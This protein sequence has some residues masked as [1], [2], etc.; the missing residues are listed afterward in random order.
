MAPPSKRRGALASQNRGQKSGNRGQT[1]KPKRRQGGKGK[2]FQKGQETPGE[3]FPPGVSGNP[4]GRPRALKEV[5][6]FI[7]GYG[8]DLAKELV[9]I[10][11]WKREEHGFRDSAPEH[12]ERIQAIKEL[13]DRGY[14]RSVQSVEVSGPGGGAVET[15]DVDVMSSAERGRRLVSL[16]IKAGAKAVGADEPEPEGEGGGGSAGP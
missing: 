4:G 13:L 5:K 16:F 7:Q 12:K 9:G 6:E 1:K 15:R 3:K 14:G 8:L 10:V 11:F 2:P